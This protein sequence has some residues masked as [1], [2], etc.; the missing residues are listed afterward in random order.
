MNVFKNQKVW[1]HLPSAAE[2]RARLDPG[3]DP[4]IT[5]ISTDTLHDFLQL[6][7]VRAFYNGKKK[8]LYRVEVL[9]YLNKNNNI[10][11]CDLNID[12]NDLILE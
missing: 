10:V 9:Y 2:L 11:T 5:K 3:V 12:K 8:P 1:D 4:I 7:G 6:F